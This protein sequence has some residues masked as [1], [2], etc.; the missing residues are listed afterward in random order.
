VAKYKHNN[1]R[2]L[3]VIFIVALP[4]HSMLKTTSRPT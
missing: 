2:D 3:T 4:V 1:I